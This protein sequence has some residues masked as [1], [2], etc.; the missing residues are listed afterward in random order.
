MS[1]DVWFLKIPKST[2]SSF[3]IFLGKNLVI[4]DFLSTFKS[5]LFSNLW[6][7]YDRTPFDE[8]TNLSNSLYLIPGFSPMDISNFFCSSGNVSKKP[9]AEELI[10]NRFHLVAQFA[11]LS[12]PNPNKVSIM[13]STIWGN[14]ILPTVKLRCQRYL[15]MRVASFPLQLQGL[16]I[17]MP[18][19]TF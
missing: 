17:P 16:Q 14:S 1:Y 2:I 6:I 12:N 15:W 13:S 10:I 8:L 19:R 9:V 3:E 7:W 18:Q 11:G 4:L 5:S